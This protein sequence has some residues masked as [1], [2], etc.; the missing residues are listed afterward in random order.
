M[1]SPSR[2]PKFG[3]IGAGW[4]VFRMARVLKPSA[5]SAGWPPVEDGDRLHRGAVGDDP[6]LHAV[7]VGL[8]YRKTV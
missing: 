6:D 5:T 8:V 2:P 7:A 1:V 4:Q 3:D